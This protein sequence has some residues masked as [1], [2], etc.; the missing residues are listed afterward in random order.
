MGSVLPYYFIWSDNY[1]IFADILKNCIRLH[2]NL[3]EIRDEYIPQSEFDKHLDHEKGH[4]FLQGCFLKVKKIKT[5]L[6]TLPENTYFIF[7]DADVLLTPNPI[8]KDLME[9]YIKSNVDLVFMRETRNNPFNNVGFGLYK[10]CKENRDLMDTVWMMAQRTPHGLDGT[11]TNEALETYK[12]V[13]A[14]FP[15]E[16]VMTSC[17]HIDYEKLTNVC[18]LTNRTLCVFQA[19]CDIGNSKEQMLYQK[20]AQFKSLGYPIEFQ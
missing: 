9:L 4:H 12:G 11:L 16:Y 13:Y 14:Q 15:T 19:L 6:E 18:A 5:L 3:F 10:V 8:I 1:K 17:T 2:P 7:S 20:L